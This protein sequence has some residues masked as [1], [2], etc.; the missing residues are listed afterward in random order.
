[1]Q[2]ISGSE[3]GLSTPD[4]IQASKDSLPA[5]TDYVEIQGGTHAFFGDYGEQRGD[6]QA[7]V[8]R[9]QA[10]AQIQQAMLDFL[11]QVPAQQP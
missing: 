4:D 5:D 10:Q 11:G 2:S 8:S 3:D 1:V 6:G 7:T 9:E